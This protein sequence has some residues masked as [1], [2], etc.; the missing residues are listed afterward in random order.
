MSYQDK[1][2]MEFGNATPTHPTDFDLI[3][4][5]SQWIGRGATQGLYVD[6]TDW[7][8]TVVDLKSIHDHAAR[9]L[10]EYPAGSGRW[11]AAPCETDA[12]GMAYRKDWLA[13]PKEQE[14][15]KAKYGRE[16]RVPDSWEEFR[17]V[18]EFFQRPDQN[19]FGCTFTTSRGYDGLTMGVQNLLWSFG[20]MWKAPDSNQV[21]GFVDSQGSVDAIDFF[22]TLL[23]L[24]PKGAEQLDYGPTVDYFKNGSLALCINYFAFCPGILESMGDKAGFAVVPGHDGKR[25]PSLGGQGMSLSTKIPAAR[26]EMAKKFIAWF[27]KP[28]TQRKWI[29][30]PAG[31][32]ANVEILKSDAFRKAAPYNAPFADSIDHMQDFWNV[33]CFNELLSATQKYVGMAVD[34]QMPT[35]EALK[36]LAEEKEKILKENGLL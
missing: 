30:K 21:K 36:K 12:V 6:L 29:T 9:Y 18:A 32:T 16:L 27:L 28:E 2:F 17:D 19:R 15:F 11:F 5:D 4:G 14:A 8:K 3:V 23:K 10:C 22:K 31:F 25:A 33:P 35:A 24:G 13:D 7:L 20:G 26:Q 34:G 1:A